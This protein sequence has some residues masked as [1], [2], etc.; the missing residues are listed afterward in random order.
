MGGWMEK[1]DMMDLRRPRGVK[2][3]W[4]CW[5]CSYADGCVAVCERLHCRHK[6]KHKERKK[7]TISANEEAS[8]VSIHNDAKP[9]QPLLKESNGAG[10]E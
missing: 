7:T 2:A 1:T 3:P 9:Q 4:C 8:I 10:R 6:K 5:H